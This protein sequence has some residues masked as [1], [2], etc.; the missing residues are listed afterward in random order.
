MPRLQH[1]SQRS[2]RA[3][4]IIMT[5]GEDHTAVKAHLTRSAGRDQHELRGHEI[6]LGNIIFIL[7]EFQ[8]ICLYRILFLTFQRLRA[9]EDIKLLTLDDL[10]RILLHLLL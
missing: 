1:S 5:I 10:R 2:I 7:D 4:T 3:D 6:L 9:D 8:D